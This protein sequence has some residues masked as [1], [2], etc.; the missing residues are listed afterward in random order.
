MGVQVET[1]KPGDGQTFPK[2]GQTVIVHYTGTLQNGQKFD[3]SRD[4]GSPFKFQIG[5]G[6]VIKGWDEG[7]AQMSVGQRAK[8]TCS[9]D[10]AYG[11][12]GHPGI[13]PQIPPLFSTSSCLKLTKL[14]VKID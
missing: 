8:L 10:Y 12:R 4:R 9:P 2:T 11:S 6:E 13:I 7:V 14:T 3:S 1:I 5:K